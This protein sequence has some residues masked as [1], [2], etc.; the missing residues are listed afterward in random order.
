MHTYSFIHH[1]SK[2]LLTIPIMWTL[3]FSRY[4]ARSRSNQLIA[5]EVV[6]SCLT[7]EEPLENWHFALMLESKTLL[8]K[9]WTHFL[10]QAFWKCSL[11]LLPTLIQMQK[12][13]KN[14]NRSSDLLHQHHQIRRKTTLAQLSR[15]TW[16]GTDSSP[17]TNVLKI[18][19]L[20]ACYLSLEMPSFLT[21]VSH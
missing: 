15:H 6:S 7:E 14:T 18:Y 3:S 11:R 12:H 1:S 8:K 21:R 2:S 20:K 5:R 13:N 9:T 4:L 19:I 16:L 17:E 10:I